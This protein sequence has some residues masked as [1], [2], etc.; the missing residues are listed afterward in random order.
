[1]VKMFTSIPAQKSQQCNT[2]ENSFPFVH[3]WICLTIYQ[4]VHP[5]PHH[6]LLKNN[7]KSLVILGETSGKLQYISKQENSLE[8]M[9][10]W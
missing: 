7:Q 9:K 10:A 3:Q 8:T 1:M 2:W 6:C 4:A 5:S